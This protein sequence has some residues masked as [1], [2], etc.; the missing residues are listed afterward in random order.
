MNSQGHKDNV[1]NGAYGFAGTGVSYNGGRVY[2][3]QV[4]MQGC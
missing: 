4:F 1:L 3:V 2:V